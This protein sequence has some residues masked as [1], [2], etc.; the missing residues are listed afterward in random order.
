MKIICIGRNY[1]EHIKELANERP[2]E[3]VV[4]LK[5]ETALV[6]NNHSV[7]YPEF[8]KDLHH[9]LEIVLRISRTGRNIPEN[10]A[11]DYFDTI[12]LGIDF[13]A[14]DLQAK[15]KA[16]GLPW[17]IA[18]SFDSSAP[19]SGFRPKTDFQQLNS[20]SFR[21]E[22]NGTIRQKGNTADMMFTFD[23]II[24]WCSRFFTL[25][26]GDLI[27]T[28][29]PSGVGPVQPGDHLEGFLEGEKLLDFKML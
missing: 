11:G 1:A 7:H 18:K 28:G 26:P 21:L 23:E 13:T 12:G 24:S 4:F 5:P 22:V 2:E 6:E 15:Q 20:L 29:T 19:V 25:Q 17:E 3:P 8:T 9:E 27:F 16:K 14:R 10:K